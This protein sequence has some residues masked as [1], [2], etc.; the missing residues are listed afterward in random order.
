MQ[1]KT[2]T[3]LVT[4]SDDGCAAAF[5]REV[6]AA[7]VKGALETGIKRFMLD[8]AVA[9]RLRVAAGEHHLPPV[10]SAEVDA[11]EG[12]RLEC[13]PGTVGYTAAMGPG[14]AK[15]LHASLRGA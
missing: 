9:H 6:L 3:L 8:R 14:A 7:A 1:T 4:I 15:R 10:V 11:F 13:R 5:D 12:D 2:F